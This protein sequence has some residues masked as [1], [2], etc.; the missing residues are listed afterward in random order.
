MP[1]PPEA[2]VRLDRIKGDLF[3]FRLNRREQRLLL[4]LLRLYPLVPSQHHRLTRGS[5][6]LLLEEQRL[7]DEAL[8]E[9]RAEN[10]R[11]L[12]AFLHTDGRFLETPKGIEL[13]LTRPQVEWFLQVLNDIRVGSWLLAGSPDAEDGRPPELTPENL[14]HYLTMELAVAFQA[15]LLKALEAGG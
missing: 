10:R 7:L 8:A 4:E 11:Q 9:H 14:R 2:V 6:P 1:A 12:E 13:S 3:V 5:D 15:L